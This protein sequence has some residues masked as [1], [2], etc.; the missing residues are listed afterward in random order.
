MKSFG[1]FCCVFQYQ[2][3]EKGY[4]HGGCEYEYL[5]NLLDMTSHE[6]ALLCKEHCFIPKLFQASLN[7]WSHDLTLMPL[8]TVSPCLLSSSATAATSC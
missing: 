3:V 7:T 8:P 6:N 1:T 5:Q 2:T 4:Q